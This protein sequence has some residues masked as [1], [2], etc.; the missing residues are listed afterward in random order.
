[1]KNSSKQMGVL[2]IIL[3]IG[4]LALIGCSSGGVTAPKNQDEVPRTTTQQIQER[5]EQGEEILIVDSRSKASYD[6][7][8]IQ[9]AISVPVD[10][11]SERLDEL[12]KDKEIVFYCT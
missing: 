12:P 10:E 11:V 6:D 2:L 3:T 1:M 4:L 9:G 8:H 7:R 5:I